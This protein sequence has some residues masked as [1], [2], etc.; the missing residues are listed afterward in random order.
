MD[1]KIVGKIVE[2]VFIKAKKEHASH[3]KFALSSHVSN[4]TNLSAKTLERA[5]DKYINQKKKYGVPQAESIDLLCKY[6]GYEDFRDYVKHNTENGVIV[7]PPT[8]GI[9]K[10]KLIITIGIAFGMILLIFGIQKW[11]IN[12]QVNKST[13]EKCMTWA[14]SHYV[15]ISC[16]TSPL[17]KFGTKVEPIDRI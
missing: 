3:S 6:L 5:Y 16:D 4:E 10:R 14:D 15:T 17:S 1:E 2:E 9:D 12:N 8:N 13:V 7:E 11:S